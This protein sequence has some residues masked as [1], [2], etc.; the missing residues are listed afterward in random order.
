[1]QPR[2]PRASRPSRLGRGPQACAQA[3][4]VGRGP[5]PCPAGLRLLHSQSCAWTRPS[6]LVQAPQDSPLLTPLLRALAVAAQE[7]EGEH[8]LVTSEEREVPGSVR[9]NETEYFN[10]VF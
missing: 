1:M 2:P 7:L 8:G 5:S 4:L 3:S 9:V 6:S 10:A